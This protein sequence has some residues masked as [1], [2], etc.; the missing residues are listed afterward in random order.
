MH[1]ED[2]IKP[3]QVRFILDCIWE[4]FAK[5][6]D[7]Y[8]LILGRCE[9]YPVFFKKDITAVFEQLDLSTASI[10]AINEDKFCRAIFIKLLVQ[11]YFDAADSKKD[12]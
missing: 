2:I 11:M 8:K 5:I 4:N 9:N 6:C 1:I 10:K 3:T 12:E 7:C